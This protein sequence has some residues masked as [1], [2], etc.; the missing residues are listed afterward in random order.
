MIID[1]EQSEINNTT[2]YRLLDESSGFKYLA[3]G[4]GDQVDH[5]DEGLF[6]AVSTGSGT[7]GLEQAV[8]SL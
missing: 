6:I 7:S 4:A 1:F 2:Y 8:E 5:G 3:N